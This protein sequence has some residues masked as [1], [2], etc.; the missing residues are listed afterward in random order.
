MKD[1]KQFHKFMDRYEDLGGQILDSALPNVAYGLDYSNNELA[2]EICDAMDWDSFDIFQSIDFEAT[3][4][5]A[6]IEEV[7]AYCFLAFLRMDLFYT[8]NAM[9]VGEKSFNMLAAALSEY[10]FKRL[11]DRFNFLHGD[12][13]GVTPH[14]WIH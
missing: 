9:G 11:M 13:E 14:P 8:A 1:S 12:K 3:Y 7:R 6:G 2:G 4:E 5:N 10:W